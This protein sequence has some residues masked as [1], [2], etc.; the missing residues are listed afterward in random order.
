MLSNTTSN[1]VFFNNKLKSLQQQHKKFLFKKY[2]F[3][4]ESE[5]KFIISQLKIFNLFRRKK[6]L[7]LSIILV[8]NEFIKK[9]IK[10]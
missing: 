10:K 1:S 4:H 3:I 6:D 8:L 7:N 2:K 5:N 9:K